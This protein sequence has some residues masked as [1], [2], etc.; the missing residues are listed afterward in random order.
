M[1]KSLRPSRY[2]HNSSH[3]VPTNSARFPAAIPLA[4]SVPALT[5]L[6]QYLDAK[7][8]IRSD[9]SLIGSFIKVSIR[10]SLAEKRDQVSPF[11]TLENYALS[12]KT[13]TKTFIYF[14]GK[15]WTYRQTYEAVLKY[16]AWMKKR[17]D[18]Q[19]GEVIAID[20]VNSEVFVFVWFG[21]WSIGAKP[22]FLN[23]NLVDKPLLHSVK[24]CGTRM[25]FVDEQVKG[26]FD[27]HV[28]QEL[29]NSSFRTEGGDVKVVIFDEVVKK[30]IEETEARRVPNE[31]RGG[32]LMKD[33]AILIYTSGTTGMPKPAVVSWAK[34][35]VAA[36]FVAEWMPWRHDDVF[37]TVCSPNFHHGSSVILTQ[38][39]VHAAVSFLSCPSR[40]PISSPGRHLNLTRGQ[41]PPLNVLG[42]GTSYKRNHYPIRRGNMSIP[43]VRPTFPI[44]QTAQSTSSV[45]QRTASRRVA[46]VQGALRHRHN[47]GILRRNRRTSGG[48][49][50]EPEPIH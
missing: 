24:V 50:Q 3:N 44:R 33:M 13:A 47:C 2:L 16:G 11:Y 30:E 10:G 27:G 25:V 19:K 29:A 5:A 49:E 17:Y 21:L 40:P 36:N 34:A 20:F 1:W 23:Y 31:E 8:H 35:G 45:R 42:G 37:Y 39:I 32:Q 14:G 46:Q 41:I 18:V 9:L 7:F 48:V 6:F 22:A 12:P 26:N 43:N 28:A 4:Y 38:S 15:S